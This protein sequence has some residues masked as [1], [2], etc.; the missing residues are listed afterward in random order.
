MPEALDQQLENS[1][2]DILLLAKILGYENIDKKSARIG[3]ANQAMEAVLSKDVF[4]YEHKLS[5]IEKLISNI[6][7]PFAN[8]LQYTDS[9]SCLEL[10]FTFPDGS[11]AKLRGLL[12]NELEKF[13]NKE[14]ENELREFLD[15]VLFQE[16]AYYK[17]LL[18][19]R[20]SIQVF[21]PICF[22]FDSEE[23]N[24]FLNKLKNDVFAKTSGSKALIINGSGVSGSGQV[25]TLGYD[26]EEKEWN[27]LDPNQAIV[28]T[29]ETDRIT[30]KLMMIFQY[31]NY[32][33]LAMDIYGLKQEKKSLSPSFMTLQQELEKQLQADSA[34]L[35]RVDSVG[36]TLLVLAAQNEY[37]QWIEIVLKASEDP[38]YAYDKEEAK[39]LRYTLCFNM[40]ENNIGVMK[41]LLEQD[42]NPNKVIDMSGMTLIHLA[43]LLQ[44]I[45][46][47][48]LLVHYGAD[49]EINNNMQ[50]TAV[51][52][53]KGDRNQ[54]LA[55]V[56][57]HAKNMLTGIKNHIEIF[58]WNVKEGHE[59]IINDKKRVILLP[60]HVK[61][62]WDEIKKAENHEIYWYKALKK[63]IHI[64]QI[65]L[66]Y[67][68][69]AK[70]TQEYYGFFMASNHQT[71]RKN[72]FL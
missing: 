71:I 29:S 28:R 53:F 41:D 57:Q 56:E 58:P 69:E 1:H 43:A 31:A 49:I 39:L 16:P 59:K 48:S 14:Q 24:L 30:K 17:Y 44:N 12:E 40:K 64:A 45:E 62:Q 20:T 36:N 6:I 22:S 11:K 42:I 66:R 27:L 68:N 47:I 9:S 33:N 38:N 46:M 61:L 37:D 23:L 3:L 25:V 4:A 52:Y 18:T 26:P 35:T 21:S 65:A 10:F 50:K 13:I 32:I 63:V 19:E 51:D 72:F 8:K 60:K 15:G 54:L 34:K 55:V 2:S 5:F 7:Q 70:K 67:D